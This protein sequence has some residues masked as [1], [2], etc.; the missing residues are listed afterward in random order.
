[1]RHFCLIVFYIWSDFSALELKKTYLYEKPVLRWWPPP[2][3]TPNQLMTV[4]GQPSDHRGHHWYPGPR[5]ALLP[6][7]DDVLLCWLWQVS[8]VV[9]PAGAGGE[10]SLWPLLHHCWRWLLK[11]LPTAD[12]VC[13]QSKTK[14]TYYNLQW[15]KFDVWKHTNIKKFDFKNKKYLNN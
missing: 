10:S 7:D 9:E 15:M 4:A 6:P 8:L 13:Y 2:T 12:V 3:E 1:M 14:N 5:Q 11:R